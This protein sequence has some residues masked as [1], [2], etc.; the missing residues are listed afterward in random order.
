[1]GK[2]LQTKSFEKEDQKRRLGQSP[3]I[4]TFLGILG[5]RSAQNH[6]APLQVHFELSNLSQS[7]SGISQ[8]QSHVYPP[9]VTQDLAEDIAEFSL[10]LACF[11]P[12]HRFL[13]R[14]I[15]HVR[16]DGFERI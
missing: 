7:L 6:K 13:N 14:R 8:C 12:C 10:Q 16:M 1:M 4:Q 2:S 5:Q 3:M 11:C 9:R 15:G